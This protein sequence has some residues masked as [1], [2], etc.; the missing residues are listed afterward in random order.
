MPE[1]SRFFGII[2][3]MYYSDHQPPHFHAR[4]SGQKAQVTI[5]PVSILRGDLPPRVFG[6]VAEWA[7]AHRAELIENWELSQN[8][9]PPNKIDPLE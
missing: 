9:T 8:E 4:Y 2:I 1:I 3:T 5:E 6:L 7:L